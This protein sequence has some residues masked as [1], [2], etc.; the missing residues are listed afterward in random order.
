MTWMT[1]C[2]VLKACGQA[3]LEEGGNV[4]VPTDR[5]KTYGPSGDLR[6]DYRS[7]TREQGP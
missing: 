5:H 2:L 6:S 4:T 3:F 7:K 1:I